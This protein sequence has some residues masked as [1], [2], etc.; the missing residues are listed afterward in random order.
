MAKRDIKFLLN[1]IQEASVEAARDACVDIMNSLAKKGPAWTGR[2]SSAWY[3]LAPG[4]TAGKARSK[5]SIYKYDLRNVPKTRFKSE[6]QF[7]IVNGMTYA[8]QAQDLSPFDPKD[9]IKQR[10]IKPIQKEGVRPED[11]KR[12]ELNEGK[13]NVRT[14]PLDWYLD[15]INGG[16]LTNDLKTGAK[17]G[18]GRFK[19]KGFG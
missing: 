1:D 13:G 10:P 14:A 11:G 5:G 19:P 8:D 7:T 6:G 15:Y 9:P 2:Y 12:G 18:F 16:A 17:R 3:A 4:Q